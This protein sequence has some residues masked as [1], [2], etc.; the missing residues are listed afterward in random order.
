MNLTSWIQ[1]CRAILSCKIVRF[2][3]CINA[4]KK[5]NHSDY[6]LFIHPSCMIFDQQSVMM[7]PNFWPSKYGFVNNSKFTLRMNRSK[8]RPS[9]SDQN[10]KMKICKTALI[11]KSIQKNILFWKIYIKL[12]AWLLSMPV[13]SV[14]PAALTQDMLDTIHP[15]EDTK[16]VIRTAFVV[17]FKPWYTEMNQKLLSMRIRK[18]S[19]N[20]ST[21]ISWFSIKCPDK[22]INKILDFNKFIFVC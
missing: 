11:G 13:G 3:W 4:I 14:D 2:F 21:Y 16:L 9:I 1:L 18:I 19:T 7:W 6:Q 10:I 8:C 17:Q 5:Q 15:L 22:R 12:D 20:K